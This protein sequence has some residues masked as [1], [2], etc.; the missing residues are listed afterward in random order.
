MLRTREAGQVL[1]FVAVCLT[2]LLGFSR[3]ATDV[4]YW[5]YQQREQQS[6]TDAAAIGGAQTLATESCPSSSAATTAARDDAQANGYK[7][8]GGDSSTG[9]GSSSGITVTVDNPPTSGPYASN[10]CA[11][12][13]QITA[14]H[15]VF[16]SGLFGVK[17]MPISTSATALLT[18]SS[19]ITVAALGPSPAPSGSPSGGCTFSGSVSAPG[20]GIECNG[21]VTC[22]SGTIDAGFIG[23]VGSAS[24]SGCTF[25]AATP[26]PMPS[27]GTVN[28]CPQISGCATVEASPPPTTSCTALAPNMDATLQP[29]CYSSFPV[30]SCGTVTLEPGTYVLTGTSDFSNTSFV[31]TGVTFYVTSTGTPPD[32]SSANSAT[33]SAPTSGSYANVLYYQVPS[34]TGSPNFSGSSVHF[35]GLIYAPGATVTYSGDGGGKNS[36]IIGKTVTLDATTMPSPSPGTSIMSKVVLAQ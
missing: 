20:S 19:P 28:P 5:E 25:T 27:T 17:D 11:V 14:P 36:V 21:P 29:G 15:A 12:E 8:A 23:Y 6:A 4:G 2:V 30:G 9:S 3:M 7:N 22:T 16:F 26:A 18:Q 35:T 1:P 10:N 33:I 32:F 31:G 13:V 24:T 34:N